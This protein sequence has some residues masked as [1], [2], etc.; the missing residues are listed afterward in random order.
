MEIKLSEVLRREIE[1]RNE[2]IAVL[3]KNT[4]IPRTT[5]HDWVHGRLP[6][7]RNLKYVQI[8]SEYFNVS[9]ETLLFGENTQFDRR[10][11]L[12][13]SFFQDGESKYRITVEEV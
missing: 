4:G 2:S 9:L 11:V 12:F 1:S 3:S 6:S 13:N 7:S 8:L 10:N 5:L